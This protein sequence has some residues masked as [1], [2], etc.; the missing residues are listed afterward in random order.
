MIKIIE[1][2]HHH[3][4]QQQQQQQQE[5]RQPS[6]Q[7]TKK[8]ED[9][10]GQTST[11]MWHWATQR[12]KCRKRTKVESLMLGILQV[13]RVHRGVQTKKAP[14]RFSHRFLGLHLSADEGSKPYIYSHVRTHTPNKENGTASDKRQA[15]VDRQS[16]R[17]KRQPTTQL[18]KVSHAPRTAPSR[19]TCHFGTGPARRQTYTHAPKTH[20]RTNKWTHSHS[21][22]KVNISSTGGET[23]LSINHF[24]SPSIVKS[25]WLL[26][27][28]EAERSQTPPAVQR[29]QG[30]QSAPGRRTVA[31]WQAG[32]TKTRSKPKNGRR[33][34]KTWSWWKREGNFMIASSHKKPKRPVSVLPRQN[35]RKTL[36][37]LPRPRCTAENISVAEMHASYI[38]PHKNTVTRDQSSCRR[39]RIQA[40]MIT[41]RECVCTHAFRGKLMNMRDWS[42]GAWDAGFCWLVSCEF[43]TW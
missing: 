25:G 16:S 28:H 17:S 5:Q 27:L 34:T 1:Q 36:K 12:K 43:E 35:A 19:S 42:R 31:R 2:Q 37:R 26:L 6:P 38:D 3:H 11:P 22:V 39:Q 23:W 20:T 7:M 14:T 33:H 30:A 41:D 8:W 21:P 29:Y 10:L 18:W 32:S 24:P 40:R 4:H 15:T 13:A 9:G